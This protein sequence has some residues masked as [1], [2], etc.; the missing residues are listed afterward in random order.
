MLGGNPVFD[1]P[2]DFKFAQALDKVPFRAHL[3]ASTTTRRRCAAHWHIPETH[4][5]E[6][7]G[8]AR[9]HDGTV[10]IMQPLIAPL[11][12]GRSPHEVLGALIGG[13]DSVAVRHRARATGA[14]HGRRHET[15]GASGSRRRRS[16]ARAL[17]RA[18]GSRGSDPAAAT[19]RRR[20]A[21]RPRA[22]IRADPTI[23]DGRFANNG[24]LQ[25][26]P[27]PQYEDH[28]GTTSRSSRRRPRRRLGFGDA[29][30]RADQRAETR[31]ADVKYRGRE[32]RAAGVGRARPC[33]RRR[34]RCTSATAGR[35]AAGSQSGRTA[36]GF[37]VYPLRFSDALRRRR[38]RD[39]DR[40]PTKRRP[41][42]SPA[43][44][45]TRAST[46][47]HRAATA[48][49]SAPDVR[50]VPRTDF[51]RRQETSSDESMYPPYK[52]SGHAWAMV[53]DTSVCTGCNGCVVACQA[54]NNIAVVGKEE[55]HRE[56]EMHWLRIDRYYRGDP[57]NPEVYHQPVPCMQCENAPCEPVCPV[58]A[59]SH[60]AEGLNDMTYNRCVG[61]RYCSNNCPYKVRRFNFF[62]Y[63]DYDTPALKPMRNPDVTVRTRG[64]M[65]K[66]TY[67]V[68]RINEAKI[69]AEKRGP[70]RP[71]RRDRHRLPA[72]LPDRGD[73]LRRHRTTRRAAC[74]KL[75][76][77]PHELRAARRS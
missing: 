53:I 7:W 57:E 58:E 17:P 50:R 32:R 45:S 40:A 34:S 11:Y 23:H 61:T 39:R 70:A 52:Y 19:G 49:S 62:H 35:R 43:R 68:Q 21:G 74:R 30:A 26:L 37:N 9:G 71:R 18:G 33:R 63:S 10:S 47:R 59:T 55:V 4:Y 27:K 5:L 8:D 56:R 48:A 76:T 1:A 42:R 75:K 64:V 25:E 67:C 46:S 69:E 54:E 13:L 20:E 66:C 28:A 24:W 16:P 77:E 12:N 38:R 6:T 22:Q 14:Q 51:A 44:R 15:P 72:G 73:R 65:E 41:T 31:V 29:S 60:S 3:V 36:I 2:A